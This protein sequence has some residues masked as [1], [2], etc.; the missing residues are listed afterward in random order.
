MEAPVGAQGSILGM[1]LVSFYSMQKLPYSIL[2]DLEALWV[3]GLGIKS[4][5]YPMGI[6][7]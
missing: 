4:L 7:E 1:V 3:M 6:W 5:G 2:V